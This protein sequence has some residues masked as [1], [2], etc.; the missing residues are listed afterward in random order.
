MPSINEQVVALRNEVANLRARQIAIS[1]NGM[2]PVVVGEFVKYGCKVTEGD[3][4]P[5]DNTIKLQ[6]QASGDSANLNPKLS[7][8]P[9]RPFEYPNIASCLGGMFAS[10][11]TTATVAA[12]PSTGTGR[13]D[14]AYIFAGKEGAGFA[15]ATGTPSASVKT[16]F[17][18]NGLQTESYGTGS[19][20]FDPTLPAGAV[21][22]ARIYV[23][24]DVTGIPN[25]RI[26][27]IRNL[28]TSLFDGVLSAANNLSDVANAASAATNLGLGP[29]DD[30]EFA[31]VSLSSAVPTARFEETDAG[32]DEKRFDLIQQ[33]ASVQLRLVNDAQSASKNIF[34]IER[35]GTTV[36]SIAYGNAT[37]VP[38]HVF[39][40]NIGA[41]CVP[42]TGWSS[43]WDVVEIGSQGAFA[44]LSGNLYI[45]NNVYQDG[46]DWRYM[47]DGA[48]FVHYIGGSGVQILYRV[49]SG[50]ADAVATLVEVVRFSSS[51]L[52]VDGG[53]NT[54]IDSNGN[55]AYP[56]TTSIT[57]GTTQ[58]L[59]GST[60][61]T[62]D[63]NNV[64]T[65]ANTGDGVRLPTAVA[66]RRVSIHNNGANALQ[67]WPAGGDTIDGGSVNAV[68]PNSLAA[69]SHRFYEAIDA[70]NWETA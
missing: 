27:D 22:V 55:R 48:G 33:N 53:S 68:D 61:L 24:D 34:Q 28:S 9:V 19:P 15:V 2:V 70:T 8:T 52:S 26:A 59:A 51:G 10:P 56:V 41:N 16:D 5:L 46:S 47:N 45:T 18:S 23:E 58:T 11:D 43:S 67:V 66:G 14:I 21:P 40:G 20:D 12:A 62:N 32:T 37:D 54:Q 29:D 63:I 60:A 42:N 57:A 17:D 4:S 69:G 39:Y 30:T 13:Y 36:D 50:T 31:T 25:S 64:T 6:G 1:V 44:K 65:V 38:D 7:G 49:A 3:S 35:T